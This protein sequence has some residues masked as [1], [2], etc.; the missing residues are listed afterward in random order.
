MNSNAV[1]GRNEWREIKTQEFCVDSVDLR[2][3]MS[4]WYV[5]IIVALASCMIHCL[6][7]IIKAIE[8]LTE[9]V[10]TISSELVKMNSKLDGVESITGDEPPKSANQPESDVDAIEAIEAAI[11]NFENLKRID[12]ENP[13]QNK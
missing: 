12:S 4:I 3:E 6:W 13:Q 1:I 7:Q 10:S 5:L 2:A 9:G 8:R 11:S